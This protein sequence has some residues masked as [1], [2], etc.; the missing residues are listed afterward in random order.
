MLG[1]FIATI[2]KSLLKK[3]IG[4]HK[5]VETY[6]QIQH[7]RNGSSHKVDIRVWDAILNFEQEPLHGCF[8][9]THAN[10]QSTI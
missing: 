6:S 10:M 7:V 9:E 4:N 2:N 1:K 5:H 8:N 3:L